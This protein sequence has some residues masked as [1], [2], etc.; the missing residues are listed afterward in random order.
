MF[1]CQSAKNALAFASHSQNRAPLVAHIRFSCQQPFVLRSI[2]K[3]NRTVVLQPKS[4][5]SVCDC[6]YRTL[7]CASH[8]QQ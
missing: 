8:L 1:A 6:D 3:F 5:R 2:D 7:R 4:F